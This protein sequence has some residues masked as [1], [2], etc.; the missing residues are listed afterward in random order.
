[1]Y[2]FCLRDATF[3]GPKVFKDLTDAGHVQRNSNA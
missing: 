1:M 2:C 3:P